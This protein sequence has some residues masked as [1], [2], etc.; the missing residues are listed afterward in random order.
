MGKGL[1]KENIKFYCK[2]CEKAFE[3]LWICK[4][5]SIIG[6]RYAL[7]LSDCQKLIEIYSYIDF[8]EAMIIFNIFFD[9][10]QIRIS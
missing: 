10:L 2:H 5:N 1:Q 3:N 6:T 9:E 7:F 4:M 8:I